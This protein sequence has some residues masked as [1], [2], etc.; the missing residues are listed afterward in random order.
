[1][2][3][4]DGS[5]T[6]VVRR[7]RKDQIATESVGKDSQVSRAAQNVLSRIERISNAH[8]RRRARHQLHQSHGTGMAHHIWIEVT[9]NFDHGAQKRERELV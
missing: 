9:L 8:V 7:H 6:C 2:V 3:P 4:I 5:F 1:M